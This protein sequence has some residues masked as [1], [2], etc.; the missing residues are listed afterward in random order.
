M[1]NLKEGYMH[2]D[3]VSVL[4]KENAELGYGKFTADGIKLYAGPGITYKAVD[5]AERRRYQSHT[6]RWRY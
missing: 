6:H 2:S 5:E 1:L 3:Y 4:T